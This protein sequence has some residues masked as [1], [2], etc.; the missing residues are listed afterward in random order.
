MK[1]TTLIFSIDIRTEHLQNTSLER[2]IHTILLGGSHGRLRISRY[3][4]KL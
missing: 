3:F 1:V 4:Y 2:Q